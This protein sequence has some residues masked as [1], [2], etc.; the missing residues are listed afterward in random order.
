MR[1]ISSTFAFFAFAFFVASSAVRAEFPEANATTEEVAEN[2]FPE[3]ARILAELPSKA[4]LLAEENLRVEEARAD[5]LV[6]DA[7]RTG[8]GPDG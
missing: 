7:P 5:R 4:P 6:E 1:L 2:F 3:L 8:G